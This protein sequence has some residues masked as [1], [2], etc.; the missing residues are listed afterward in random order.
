MENTETKTSILKN[1][2]IIILGVCIAIATIASTVILSQ[3]LMKIK[4]IS[5]ELISVTGSAEKK[6]I[7]DAVVWRSD[8]SERNIDMKIAFQN[9]KNDLATVKEYLIS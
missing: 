5:T 3:G 1:S 7:S 2:Q 8:F 4:K 9:L 6:I